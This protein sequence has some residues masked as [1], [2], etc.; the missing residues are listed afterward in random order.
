M[1]TRR[2]DYRFVSVPNEIEINSG[3]MP[4]RD[5]AS[6]NGSAVRGSINHWRVLRGE[7][8]ALLYEM[9]S[10]L[11]ALFAGGWKSA[12]AL[13]DYVLTRNISVARLAAVENWTYN[14]GANGPF[15]VTETAY[16]QPTS[17]SPR[18]IAAVSPASP[19]DARAVLPIPAPSSPI[20]FASTYADAWASD[21]GHL[22][23]SS[24]YLVRELSLSPVLR[25]DY[26]TPTVVDDKGTPATLDSQD[27]RAMWHNITLLRRVV[28]P[29]YLDGPL[30]DFAVRYRSNEYASI[31]NASP[32]EVYGYSC[33][34]RASDG[35]FVGGACKVET[36]ADLYNLGRWTSYSD[37]TDQANLEARVAATFG[38]NPWA[39]I[40]LFTIHRA[41]YDGSGQY[42]SQ[43]AIATLATGTGI[44]YGMS[45]LPSAATIGNI[46]EQIAQGSSL[47]LGTTANHTLH[48]SLSTHLIVD[49]DTRLEVPLSAWNW[50]G[51][52]YRQY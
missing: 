37:A 44:T 32:S 15:V 47:W 36:S 10:R 4:I 46:A 14:R 21:A 2:S 33:Y 34:P 42:A 9:Y 38:D 23:T 13:P 48:V 43:G 39:V 6:A 16:T 45:A 41:M 49:I 28:D 25:S 40:G 31:G 17:I 30:C 29:F 19:A 24:G 5:V 51:T 35:Q 11:G 50:P 12:D 22:L 7:D 18:F 26:V 8:P 27:I 20:W 1:I 3:I 52:D